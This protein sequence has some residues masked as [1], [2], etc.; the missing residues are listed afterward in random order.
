[1]L[2]TRERY[3][4]LRFVFYVDSALGRRLMVAIR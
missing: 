4:E 2:A 1:V 3:N